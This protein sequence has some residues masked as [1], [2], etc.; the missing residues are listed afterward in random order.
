MHKNGDTYYL[1]WGCFYATGSSVYGPFTMGGSVIDTAK[2]APDF[3]CDGQPHQCGA[4]ETIPAMPRL[5]PLMPTSTEARAE[6]E[7]TTAACCCLS[8][9]EDL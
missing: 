5:D 4:K 3:Q 8:F 9:E 2:I 6:G 1:S 7:Y